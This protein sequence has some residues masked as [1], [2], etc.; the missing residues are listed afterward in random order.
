MRNRRVRARNRYDQEISHITGSR[1]GMPGHVQIW[2][3]SSGHL[4]VAEYKRE[5]EQ[6]AERNFGKLPTG[7]VD[8]G[9]LE[10]VIDAAAPAPPP[11]H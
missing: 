6:R 8:I 3:H 7:T 5:L 2:T 10:P 11:A 4:E 9:P 1:V